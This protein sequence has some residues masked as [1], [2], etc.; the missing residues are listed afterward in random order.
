MIPTTSQTLPMLTFSI[1][2]QRYAISIEDVIE[3]ASIVEIASIA[4]SRPELLGVVNRHGDVLPL[5]DLR[6]LLGLE[7]TTIDNST[8]FIVTQ[9]NE[10]YLGLVV[11]DVHQVEYIEQSVFKSTVGAGAIVQEVATMSDHLLQ[12]INLAPLINDYVAGTNHANRA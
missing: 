7:K 4:D 3:V 11:D 9:Y 5:L 8:L 1:D 10:Q 12:R 2:K 6:Q